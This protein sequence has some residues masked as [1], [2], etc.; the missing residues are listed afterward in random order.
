MGLGE[1]VAD[2]GMGFLP[3][4]GTAQGARDFERA[5]RD[6]DK[7]GMLLSAA[8]MIPVAGGAV[9]AVRSAGKAADVVEEVPGAAR[10]MLDEVAPPATTEQI[11]Q[12][13]SSAPAEKS[14]VPSYY[15]DE[16]TQETG[17]SPQEIENF[18]R[19]GDNQR[20]L[21]EHLMVKAQRELGGGVLFPAIEHIGDLTNRMT[22]KHSLGFAYEETLGKAQRYLRSLKSGYGFRREFEEN[23]RNNAQFNN[24]SLEEHRSKVNAAL[25][26]YADAHEK[27]VTYNP[28]QTLAR[29]AAVSLGRRDFE[30]AATLL[31]DFVDRIPTREDF[32]AEMRFTPEPDLTKL[33]SRELKQ[34]L[35]AIEE[36]R[37]ARAQR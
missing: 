6:E 9:R 7:L 29:D 15:M 37:R 4:V 31:Q 35:Q 23:L 16:W 19:L 8:S 11:K 34:K 22:P 27:L 32:V 1:T 21:P 2:I 14:P 30:K 20:G 28:L 18:W 5:R 3:V 12:V 36:K 33:S 25:D 24:E 13:E 10:Q 17:L 26:A